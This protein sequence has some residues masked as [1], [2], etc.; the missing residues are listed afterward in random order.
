MNHLEH[1]TNNGSDELYL[2]TIPHDSSLCVCKHC[3]SYLDSGMGEKE[4]ERE[5][6]DGSLPGHFRD[7]TVKTHRNVTLSDSKKLPPYDDIPFKK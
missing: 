1:N 7:M 3:Q 4:L 6:I 5:L 2:Y